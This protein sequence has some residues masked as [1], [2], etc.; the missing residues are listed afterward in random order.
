MPCNSPAISIRNLPTNSSAC[1]SMS[2]PSTT[3]TTAVKASGACWI[4]GTRRGLFRRRR[5]WSGCK[6][7]ASFGPR[8]S[9]ERFRSHS[10]RS[11]VSPLQAN[12]RSLALLVMTV[13]KLFEMVLTERLGHSQ[14]VAD[15]LHPLLKLKHRIHVHRHIRRG[16]QLIRHLTIFLEPVLRPYAIS[17]GFDLE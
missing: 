6:Q 11:R 7:A 1:T 12:F 10:D 17:S 16:L 14:L 13:M 15:L 2:A 8:A 3:A 9:S 4:W 5:G